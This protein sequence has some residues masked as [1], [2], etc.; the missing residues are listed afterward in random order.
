VSLEVQ[1]FDHAGGSYP[2]DGSA[3]RSL[4]GSPFLIP[5]L[6]AQLRNSTIP[7]LN[8]GEQPTAVVSREFDGRTIEFKL[9]Y[10]LPSGS[11]KDRGSRLLVSALKAFG[12]KSVVED[13]SG[14]AGASLAMYAA[15][16]GMK[17]TIVVP[18]TARG[19]VLN[20]IRMLGADIVRVPGPRERA[21]SRAWELA[22]S[23]YYASHI[24]NPL[25]HAGTASLAHELAGDPP[26]SI[27]L[28][29]GNGTLL[30]G[31]HYGFRELGLNVRI[32]AVQM[33]GLDPIVR[34]F[35]AMARSEAGTLP[36][37]H[38]RAR[39]RSV[40]RVSQIAPG[41]ATARPARLDEIVDAVKESGG[42]AVSADESL[43]MDSWH[44]L[45]KTGLHVES[46]SAVAL[47]GARL[48]HRRQV[49]GSR[50]RVMVVL[51]GSGLKR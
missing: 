47:A 12:V 34:A 11:F 32:Y 51:T 8:L 14:N 16:A 9:E 15:A 41:I 33:D 21:T 17:C 31:L 37:P 40:R 5:P 29:V 18:R 42:G 44:A 38:D 13:S 35:T 46:T 27:V 6:L 36:E 7:L 26:D 1:F 30:L 43:V 39:P 10:R 22:E 49:F 24:Y 4:D 45:G 3:W 48:L 19:P 2:A 28:P 23:S 50:D 25:F 20:Q